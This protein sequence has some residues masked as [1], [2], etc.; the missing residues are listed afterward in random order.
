[1][2][3]RDTALFRRERD[4]FTNGTVEANSCRVGLLSKT[5]LKLKTLKVSPISLNDPAI[6]IT[7]IRDEGECG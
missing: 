4:I 7:E 6:S 3:R 1:M 5:W 2:K